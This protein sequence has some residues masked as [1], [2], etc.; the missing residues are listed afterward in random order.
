MLE[1]KEITKKVGRTL[2]A[3]KPRT[4]QIY[5]L[6]KIHKNQ[7][8]VPGRPIV[9]A[10]NC[11]TERISAFADIF[12]KPMVQKSDSY[13][14]DTSDFIRKVE[15]LES[16]TPTCIIGTLDVTSLYTNI[17]NDEGINCIYEMLK[18]ERKGDINPKNE[19][20]KGILDLVLKSNNFQLNP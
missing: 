17:P 7:D 10:N 16:L 19:T 12:L 18:E 11:P 15:G 8:P 2:L 3:Q 20:I 13:V 9:S 14:K 5:F 6:P 4:P 1:E